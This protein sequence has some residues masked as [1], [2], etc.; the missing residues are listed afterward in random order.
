VLRLAQITG[1]A[2][3]FKDREFSMAWEAEIAA[4]EDDDLREVD[5]S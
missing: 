3:A 1:L 5:E 2:E 4:A